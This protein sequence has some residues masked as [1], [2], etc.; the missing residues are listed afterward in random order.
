MKADRFFSVFEVSGLAQLGTVLLGALLCGIPAMAQ[1]TA[2]SNSSSD[3]CGPPNYCARTDRRVE[4]YPKTPPAIGPAGS[5]ITDPTFGSRI[6]R[7]T[8]EKTDPR[9]PGRPL[10]T[11]SGAMENSW[12]AS[13][14]VFYV[15]NN[16][17]SFLLFD[18]NP[19]SLAVHLRDA[20]KLNWRGEPQFSFTQPNIL[21]GIGWPQAGIEQY[22]ISTGKTR[23][24]GDPSKCFAMKSSDKVFRIS[25]SGDDNR[26]TTVL[27]PEQDRNYVVMVYDREKGC[28]WY[29]TETGEIGGQWGPKGTTPLGERYSLHGAQ[30]SKSGK[31]VIIMRGAGPPGPRKWRI[32]DLETLNVVVCPVECSGHQAVGYSHILNPGGNHPLAIVSRTLDHLDSMTPLVSDLHAPPGYWYDSHLA[33]T[34]VNADDSNPACLSTYRPSNPST[35][36]T[37]LDVAGP[38]E[39][40][41]VCFETDGKASKLWRFAHTYST[42]KNGFW[43]TPRGNISPDGR[44]FMFTSDWQD[45]LGKM[46]NDKYRTDVFIVELR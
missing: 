45:Q 39:N 4:P 15:M 37:P 25:V 26:F 13:S 10:M 22:D 41:I 42:A 20:P 31:F 3:A 16:G 14:N 9:A 5:I 34:N 2:P 12:N 18:F 35:P 36:G 38:W 27:G 30:I 8:D 17:G 6:V 11:P 19:S 28:R 29:N 33:W 21:Y 23:V 7:V 43:S 32:W 44:F 24:V 1:K 46:A 40:E